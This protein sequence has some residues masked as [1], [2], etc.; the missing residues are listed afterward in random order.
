MGLLTIGAFA[1]AS[2][3]SPKALRLYD[4]L[5]LLRPARVDPVSGYRFYEPDQLE[6]A[7]LVAWLRRLGMPLARIR[8]VCE[9]EPA[10]AGREVAAYWAQVEVDVEARRHLAVFLTDHLCRED[11]AMIE[12]PIPLTI[13]Y[14]ARSDR[15]LVR[16]T[17][18]DWAYAGTRLLAVADGFGNHDAAERPVSAV[19][20]DA[21]RPLEATIP[22]GDLLNV[23]ADAARHADRAVR[24]YVTT[25]PDLAGSGTTLTAMLWSGSR[26]ALV[27]LGD[28][29]AYLLRDGE[30]SQVTHDH[31]VVRSMVDEGRLT[32]EEAESHPQRSVL[33]RALH[34][35]APCQPDLWLCE[36]RAGDRYLPCSDGL[37]TVVPVD[38]L[39][40]VLR[41]AA[42]PETAVRRLVSLA[43]SGGGPDNISCVVADV[44][45]TEPRDSSS[46]LAGRAVDEFA[47]DVELPD[48]PGVLLQQVEQDPPERRCLLGQ[49]EATPDAG[50]VGQG[51]AGRQGPRA[52]DLVGVRGQH[53]C[54]RLLRRHAP[55]LLVPTGWVGEDLLGAEAPAHPPS[56]HPPEVFDHA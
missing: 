32:P 49:L 16:E 37:Y 17:N 52:L 45:A 22:S 6:R 15:G 36:A 41:T 30:L 21:L 40:E 38:G 24:E 35:G 23:L 27:N 14:A 13:R 2:R 33:T 39:H 1:R 4:E 46:L 9:L 42:D 19:A 44:V 29:R 11:T 31:T 12:E 34:G 3:L 51:G 26:L 56:L 25:R 55:L 5:G 28:T 10:E 8:R 50:G 18:Q 20:I 7:R 47:G 43:N 54:R 48:V 53:V